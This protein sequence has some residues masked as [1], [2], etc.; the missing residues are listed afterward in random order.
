MP[1]CLPRALLRDRT[2]AAG[3]ADQGWRL[4]LPPALWPRVEAAD[5]VRTA[6]RPPLAA[7]SEDQRRRK[8]GDGHAENQRDLKQPARADAVGSPLV[9]LK[10]LIG[11]ADSLGELRLA[12]TKLG[13]PLPHARTHLY[14]DR[15]R[16]A[17]MP[18]PVAAGSFQPLVLDDNL[19]AYRAQ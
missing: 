6:C 9:F 10:L 14:I 4:R 13:A 12:K 19:P 1:S 15:V 16:G 3:S 7:S 17:P 11:G 8:K 18:A 5:R 2:T